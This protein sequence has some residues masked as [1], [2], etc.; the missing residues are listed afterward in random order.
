MILHRSR[1]WRLEP[2][3]VAVT[4]GAVVWAALLLRRDV[5]AGLPMMVTGPESVA[6]VV[7]AIALVILAVRVFGAL[8]FRFVIDSVGLT[9]RTGDITAA[10]RW[11][12]VPS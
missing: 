8:R 12:D 4:V 5:M 11:S 7:A 2:V 3:I 6:W 1:T 9:I 10:L